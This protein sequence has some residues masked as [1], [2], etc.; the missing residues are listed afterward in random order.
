MSIRSAILVIL[1]L[2]SLT[3]CRFSKSDK[4]DAVSDIT[5][6]GNEI[7]CEDIY[8]TV[9]NGVITRNSFTY[10]ETFYV[11]F[12]DVKG[13]VKE[14]GSVFP[15]MMMDIVNQAGDTIWKSGN[16]YS[17]SAEGFNY[18]PLKLTADFTAAAPV[19]SGKE[20]TL[21][22]NIWDNKGEGTFK[23]KF[24]FKVKANALIKVETYG[25]SY[26]EAY[27]LSQGSNKVITDN[28]IRYN[29]NIYVIVEGLKGFREEL[30]EVYP[31]ISIKVLDAGNKVM[32]NSED[33]FVKYDETGVSA[34]DLTARV[35]THFF[36]VQGDRFIN[37]LHCETLIWDKKS[38]ARIIVKADL[39]ME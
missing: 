31:G 14:N 29:D 6:S 34:A 8:L 26:D 18:S 33:L 32:V 27:L 1:T 20:Y 25:V 35:S 15:G 11:N 21:F 13:F 10:G 30:G 22:V 5:S 24:D 19:R 37:P 12:D 16:L 28:K 9:N 3:A 38:D 36:S 39:T 2:T 23:T 7:T 4:K 17:G